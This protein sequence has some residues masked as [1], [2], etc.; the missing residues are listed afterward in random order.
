MQVLT[1]FSVPNEMITIQAEITNLNGVVIGSGIASEYIGVEQGG[2]SGRDYK[3]INIASGVENCDTSAI[4]RALASIGLHGGEYASAN[5]MINAISG[6]KEKELFKRDYPLGAESVF[7]SLKA[8]DDNTL[9]D[10]LKDKKRI[11]FIKQHI[12]HE[13][14]LEIHEYIKVRLAQ[15]EKVKEDKK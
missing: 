1:E 13:Q 6:N 8:M 4:G 3:K 11:A 5:E 12:T 10:F 9:S 7:K 2:L 14:E 15:I